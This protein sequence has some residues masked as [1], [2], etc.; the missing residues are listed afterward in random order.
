MKRFLKIFAYT[1]I[2]VLL[3]IGLLIGFTDLEITKPITNS[4]ALK[5]LAYWFLITTMISSVVYSNETDE[6]EKEEKK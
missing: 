6:D 5:L 1:G 2:S 3:C 4:I